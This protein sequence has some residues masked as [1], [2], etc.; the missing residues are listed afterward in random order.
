MMNIWMR[1]TKRTEGY[2]SIQKKIKQLLGHFYKKKVKL[3][4]Y[5]R[6]RKLE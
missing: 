1:K 2:F 4:M 6:Q 3:K 5:V